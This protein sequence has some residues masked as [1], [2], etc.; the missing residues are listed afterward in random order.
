MPPFFTRV[1]APLATSSILITPM[2]AA[3]GCYSGGP[4]WNGVATSAEITTVLGNVCYGFEG[5]FISG[6]EKTVCTPVAS[7]GSINWAVKNNEETTRFLSWTDCIT[8]ME[9]EIKNCPYGSV[10]VHD[11]FRFKDDPNSESC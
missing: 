8:N 9:T 1:I 6:E 5:V 2:V 3:D 4:T 10:Q 7:G 11:N